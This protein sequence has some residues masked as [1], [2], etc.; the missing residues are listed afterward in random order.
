VFKN[1]NAWDGISLVPKHQQLTERE[2]KMRFLA[3]KKQYDV[4]A[5]QPE[6]YDIVYI[7]KDE[8]YADINYK[9]ILEKFPRTKR[10]HGV[11]GIHQAHIEAAKLCSTDMIWIIDADAEIVDNFK[12]D[13]YIPTYDP[14][15][16]RTV[17]VWK[18]KNPIN[19][20]IYGY[21]AVKLLPRDLTL[22]MDTNKP[23]MTT[24]I[25][26]LF[27]TIN[28]ISNITKFNTDE[29]STWR[30][31]FRECVKL[32]SRAIDGQLD[33]E[34]EFRLNAWC[35]RGKDKQFGDAAI[36]G[37]NHGKKYGEYA[38]NNQEKLYKINDYKWLRN[39]F[40]KFKNSL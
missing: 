33:E 23:D 22:N 10:I 16:K 9:N 39:Q 19:G 38:A 17:H 26:P 18:S 15:S 1:G 37:A 29:F 31:A 3:N 21:G 30:S 32:S 13:Y 14:D 8:E 11:E 40:D 6:P 28:Q 20:L 7:S 35:T 2:I 25:S 27:K 5:S 12:F 34:T 36:N 4:Q 24:S